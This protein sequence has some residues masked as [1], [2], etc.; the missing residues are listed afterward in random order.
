V[1]LIEEHYSIKSSKM[2]YLISLCLFINLISS[3]TALPVKSQNDEHHDNSNNH[4]H[5]Y[6]VG[7]IRDYNRNQKFEYKFTDLPLVVR[8]SPNQH[9]SLPLTLNELNDDEQ[10]I[11]NQQ[12]NNQ[13]FIDNSLSD[14]RN[15]HSIESSDTLTAKS[16]INSPSAVLSELNTRVNK[17]YM[18]SNSKRKEKLRTSIRRQQERTLYD[19]HEICPEDSFPNVDLDAVSKAYLAPILFIGKLSSLSE[20]YAG[21]VS[22]TFQVLRVIKTSTVDV[23]DQ[24]GQLHKV[25]IQLAKG[26]Q[27][28]LHFVRK[29]GQRLIAPHCAVF[30]NSTSIGSLRLEQKYFVYAAEPVQ[31]LQEMHRHSFGSV[32]YKA[33]MNEEIINTKSDFNS[34]NNAITN[35][36]SNLSSFNESNNDSSVDFNEST[37]QTFVT[38]IVKKVKVQNLVWMNDQHYQVPSKSNN[39]TVE[40]IPMQ[41]IIHYLS[42]FYPPEPFSRN[43]SKSISKTLCKKCAKKPQVEGLNG[44]VVVKAKNKLRLRCKIFGNPQPWIVWFRNGKRL[45]NKG[46]ISIK[47]TKKFSKLDINRVE[48]SDSGYYECRVQNVASKQPV[49]VKTRVIIALNQRKPTKA[50]T[51]QTTTTTAANLWPLI[52]QPCPI[53]NFCLNGGVCTFF[54]NVFEYVCQCAPGYRGL[55]CQEK[56]ISLNEPHLKSVIDGFNSALKT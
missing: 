9:Q 21:R 28:V 24:F 3:L 34:L 35:L 55:R 25:P 40:P 18:N 45:R 27:V 20:D 46:R 50:P 2:K 30:M 44:D 22:A 8:S 1:C 47:T 43:V 15:K 19:Q 17:R 37:N 32:S 31:S 13:Q 36:N 10:I 5:P 48:S 38:Q 52:G 11:R 7:L 42:A 33:E 16:T 4:Q 29:P 54:E 6:Q 39:E 26:H 53:N 12:V 23:K 14:D 49:V 41:F 56:D 51:E